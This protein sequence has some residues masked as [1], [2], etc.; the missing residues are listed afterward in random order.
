MNTNELMET[1]HRSVGEAFTTNKEE[2]L[3]TI[4][5]LTSNNPSDLSAALFQHATFISEVTCIAVIKT[6]ISMGFLSNPEP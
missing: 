2:Y 5:A 1:I 6:L 4:N 3:S